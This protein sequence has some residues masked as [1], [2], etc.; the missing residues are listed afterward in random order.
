M[1]MKINAANP[2][3]YAATYPLTYLESVRTASQRRHRATATGHVAA[4]PKTIS[5]AGGAMG[6][7]AV[8]TCMVAGVSVCDFVAYPLSE[9]L[10]QTSAF[11]LLKFIGG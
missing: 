10:S 3:H 2:G 5:V 8:V 9:M 11:D 6:I 1:K 4:A 7:L